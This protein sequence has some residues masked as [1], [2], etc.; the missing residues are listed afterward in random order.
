MKSILS[1]NLTNVRVDRHNTAGY[2][3]IRKFHSLLAA[4][5][6]DAAQLIA[7]GIIDKLITGNI[8]SPDAVAAI[9]LLSPADTILMLFELLFSAGASVMYARAIADFDGER[10]RKIEG[11]TII[12]TVSVS[13]ILLLLSFAG[14]NAFFDMIEATGEIREYAS[15]Y[16]FFSRF[17]FILTP[18]STLLGEFAVVDGDE[19]L[20][21]ATT[22]FDVIGDIGLSVIFC[23]KIGIAGASLGSIIGSSFSVVVLLIH[24]FKK[25]NPLR[26]VLYF[27]LRDTLEILKISAADSISLLFDTG[28]ELFIKFWFISHFG[29]ILTPVLAT[30]TSILDLLFIADGISSSCDTMIIAYRGDGNPY[31]IRNLLNHAAK[32]AVLIGAVFIALICIIAPVFPYIY[33]IRDEEMIRL[34]AIGCRIVAIEI[35][36][37]SLIALFNSYYIRTERY[38]IAIGLNAVNSLLFR[39]PLIM[40]FSSAFGMTGVWIGCGLTGYVSFLFLYLIIS[41]R[42]SRTNFP[43]IDVNIKTACLNLS[44]MITTEESVNASIKVSEYLED[45]DIDTI[46]ATRAA[47]IYEEVPLLVADINKEINKK[48]EIH[49]DTFAALEKEGVKIV[50]W[51]DGELANISDPDML[52]QDLRNFL[53]TGLFN[54]NQDVRSLMTSGYNRLS[55]VIPYP[56]NA[57]AK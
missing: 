25:S 8:V 53:I 24:F 36:P 38:A 29:M 2:L 33:G 1:K 10:A 40:I 37:Y 42:Y 19:K 48:K 44:F 16:F 27:S 22:I 4:S 55:F 50:F 14:E 57:V 39:A 51:Y 9:S 26:P 23:F 17:M 46:T 49:I 35:I 13:I 34:S 52:S 18:I 21:M 5:M 28:F 32:I 30:V 11:M 41:L 20:V 47:L 31:A 45:H 54:I 3:G 15:D 7:M 43:L 6:I 12:L 56:Q